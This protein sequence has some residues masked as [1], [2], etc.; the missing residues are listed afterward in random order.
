MDKL[1]L[2]LLQRALIFQEIED[3]DFTGLTDCLAPDI[4]YFSKNEIIHLTGDYLT[5]I[6]VIL[7]GTAAAYI[8][9]ING[10][11]TIMS[12]LT[13]M[14]VFGEILV[15]TRT[16]QSPVTVYATSDVCAGFIEYEKVYSLC[17]K[18]CAAHTAFLRN[19]I[20][21]IG[22]KY[23]LLFDRINIVR[24]KSLRS[25]ITAYLYELSRKGS[26]RVVTL[27]FSKTKL[28]EYLLVNRSALSKEL[29][30]MENDGLI[31]VKGRVIELK[32]LL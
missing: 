1:H 7:S 27:P 17:A 23:F 10:N 6:G 14:S 32:L 28:S 13:P 24:E 30:K 18:A 3:D 12:T 5:H 31:T 25:R 20:K 4:K 21:A 8:E 15:S 9:D 26:K 2:K 29:R 22:D 16:H 11:Q 19:L